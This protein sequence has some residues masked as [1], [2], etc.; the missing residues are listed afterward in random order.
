MT[1][2]FRLEDMAE[3]FYFHFEVLNIRDV[4]TVSVS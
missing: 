3:Q 4:V 1:L 2:V